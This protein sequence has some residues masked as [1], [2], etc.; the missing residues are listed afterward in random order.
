[1][2]FNGNDQGSEETK[3]KVVE[4]FRLQSKAKNYLRIKKPKLSEDDQICITAALHMPSVFIDEYFEILTEAD[5]RIYQNCDQVRQSI[6]DFLKTYPG[7]N[8]SMFAGYIGV[9]KAEL[10]RFLLANGPET[11]NIIP[12]TSFFKE[13]QS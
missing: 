3:E 2:S 12:L 6:T 9:G 11:G 4:F 7:V 13:R 5:Q 10:D 8:R 1:M